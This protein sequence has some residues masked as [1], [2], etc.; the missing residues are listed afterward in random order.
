MSFNRSR[1]KVVN[2]PESTPL[3]SRRVTDLVSPIYYDL[4]QSYRQ[5]DLAWKED[6]SKEQ[7]LR[8]LAYETNR[9]AS[10]LVSQM[11]RTATRA[12][13][14]G[15][16]PI[17]LDSAQRMLQLHRQV[18]EDALKSYTRCIRDRD[19][20]QK[21]YE[22]KLRKLTDLEKQF[23]VARA[24]TRR[25]RDEYHH[26][27]DV[28][29]GGGKGFSGEKLGDLHIKLV[30]ARKQETDAK[31]RLE[32]LKRKNHLIFAEYINLSRHVEEAFAKVAKSKRQG[33]ECSEEI[34]RIRKELR[35]E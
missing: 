31:E 17:G 4:E 1:A 14:R 9:E 5:Y 25:T 32:L 34:R 29:L 22:Q 12:L 23:E 16:S 7:A 10:D 28:T 21:N 13:N 30:H 11:A 15:I 6:W 19:L 18:F 3:P 20:F 8:K 27:Y 2:S 26:A 24:K 33:I 35:F